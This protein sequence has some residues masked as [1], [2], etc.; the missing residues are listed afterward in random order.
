[1]TLDE[2]RRMA[3]SG[4]SETVE[5]KET[6]GERNEAAKSLCAMLN[7]QGG[8]V[9]IGVKPDGAI[10]GQQVSDNTLQRLT[11]EID[12]IDPPVFPTVGRFR[13]D[14]A[15]EVISIAVGRGARWVFK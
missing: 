15:K 4:E 11:A 12:R 2:I 8:A 13:V 1:M 3:A 5:F 6:T 14:E 9:L 10:A 7:H